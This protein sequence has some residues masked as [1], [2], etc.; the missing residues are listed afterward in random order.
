MQMNS[1]VYNEI[2]AEKSI[3]DYIYGR[4]K[5]KKI[6][7]KISLGNNIINLQLRIIRIYFILN[8]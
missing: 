2:S 8:K 5:D 1:C 3:D 7:K 4:N 6:E